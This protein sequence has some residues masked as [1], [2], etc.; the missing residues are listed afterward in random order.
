MCYKNKMTYPWLFH[1]NYSIIN[2]T[3]IPTS[4]T[5]S[6]I[7]IFEY[8]IIY[9][10]FL[11][12]LYFYFYLARQPI[13]KCQEIY[14]YWWPS[15]WICKP[16]IVVSIKFTCIGFGTIDKLNTIADE[17]LMMETGVNHGEKA[18]KGHGW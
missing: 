9:Y 11:L 3:K 5:Y 16:R 10:T 7:S 2:Y 14:T 18:C 12:L 15:G 6:Y 8:V 4:Y 17:G 13:P 1:T